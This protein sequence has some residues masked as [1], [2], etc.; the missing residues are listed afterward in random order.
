MQGHPSANGPVR[1]TDW[2]TVNWRRAQRNVRNLRQ[3]ILRASQAGDHT[4]ARSLQKLMLRSY[5]NRLTSVRRVAQENAGSTEGGGTRNAD[6]SIERA[7]TDGGAGREPQSGRSGER[8]QVAKEDGITR[9]DTEAGND[10]SSQSGQAGSKDRERSGS[11][12][13]RNP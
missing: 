6:N 1:P 12:R 3:R 4:K 10:S 11:T 9:E 8:G 5:S 7:T 13:S 2:S